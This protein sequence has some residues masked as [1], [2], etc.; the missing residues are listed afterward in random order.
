M[1]TIRTLTVIGQRGGAGGEVGPVRS[2]RVKNAVGL[3]SHVCAAGRAGGSGAV[4]LVPG[5]GGA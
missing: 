1:V 2:H 5:Q 4:V 3:V